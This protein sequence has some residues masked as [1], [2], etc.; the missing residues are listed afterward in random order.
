[1]NGKNWGAILIKLHDEH[2]ISGITD[3]D[4]LRSQFNSINGTKSRFQ[5]PF[6][7]KK[8]KA[9]AK[10]PDTGVKLSN[11]EKKRLE[12]EH[13][14]AEEL[15]RDQHKNI[16]GLLKSIAADEVKATKG[17]GKKRTIAEVNDQVD[18]GEEARQNAQTMRIENSLKLAKK[19]QEKEDLLLRLLGQSVSVLENTNRLIVKLSGDLYPTQPFNPSDRNNNCECNGNDESEHII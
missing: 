9:P 5:K 3:S 15:R 17:R 6:T 1:M 10:N 8:W 19:Q 2:L 7:K 14:A 13:D 11:L 4:R 18:E 12:K 16:N